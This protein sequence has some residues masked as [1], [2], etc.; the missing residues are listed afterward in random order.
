MNNNFREIPLS[1]RLKEELKEK[2]KEFYFK[3]DIFGLNL[4]TNSCYLNASRNLMFTS[5]LRQFT[6]I[7][8]PDF[9]KVFTNYE[10]LV[11]KYSSGYYSAKNDLEIVDIIPRFEDGVNDK[12]LYTVIIYD[13]KK[14]SYDIIIKKNVEDLTEIYGFTYNNEV[15]DTLKPG[16]HVDKGTV[17]YKS[18]SYNKNMNYCYG[19]NARYMYMLDPY[20]IEDGIAIS[21]SFSKKMTSSEVH[22]L[23]VSL[24]DND[25]LCNLFGNNDE[26]KCF[27]DIGEYSDMIVCAKRRIFNNQLL[28]DVKKS[29]LRKINFNSDVLSLCSGKVMDIVIYSN[30]LIEEIPD[31]SFNKQIIK[32]LKMQERYY[33]KLYEVT[34]RI[35]ES[36]EDYS[37]DIGFYY[38]KSR[39]ILDP[40]IKW[41]DEDGS[42][43][44]NMIIEFT[45]V[46]NMPLKV[47]QKI[48][49][50]Y[51]N[52]G[53]ISEIR[54]DEDMP[55]LENGERVDVIFNTLGVINRLNPAQLYEQSI[56]FITDR[57]AERIRTLSSMKEKEELL[58]KMMSYFNEK[59]EKKL[60]KYISKLTKSEKERFFTNVEKGEIYVH[61]PPMWEKESLFD[62]LTRL[63]KE[64]DWIKPYDV[65]IRKF[66][67]R[68]K[69]IKPLVIG[70]M[71]I[72]KLKQ[73]SEK[74]FSA[75]STGSI[76][77]RGVP[78]KSN[79]NKHYQELYSKTP[80]RIGEQENGNGIIGV[81]SETVAQ[82]HLYH[83][84]S[85]LARLD[86]SK[87]LMTN[88]K[89]LKDFN[90]G[91]DFTNRNV[92][93]L[94][95]YLKALGV[96]IVFDDAMKIDIDTGEL[97][98]HIIDGKLYITDKSTY[99]D[100]LVE[101]E[102]RKKYRETE[103]FVGTP[104][105][106]E[107]LIEKET[108]E[109]LKLKNGIYID[110]DL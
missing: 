85:P 100:L 102:I 35:I 32:Y 37:S 95:A 36:G 44:S 8:N 52:K 3:D 53:I 27:P 2:E 80:I 26:Y 51:G 70:S 62:R 5:H 56:T 89:Q 1:V 101:E 4:L 88:I 58:L 76:N 67:R 19:K 63:Y 78:E 84:S 75:R 21:K 42:I 94:N 45:I 34:S 30:K 91:P 16:D 87:A 7:L 17:L 59:E 65:Y 77:K 108:Q 66:G 29:N 31:N 6:N 46:R 60:K 38:K 71:Y 98:D 14:E 92:E 23:K 25:I 74:G 55:E 49:G 39:D 72:I 50:R 61:I 107:E 110:I 48:T 79:K 22:T 13:K 81:P 82:L 96:K 99:N 12:H 41:K 90:V 47:G 9:P 69:I 28:Y 57:V 106:F 10:N 24:N 97:E 15:M 11:G 105:E 109:A 54:D 86:L 43:F 83:R 103:V 20:T 33:R 68:I 104:E 73:T 18:P 64:F 93:I 40:N